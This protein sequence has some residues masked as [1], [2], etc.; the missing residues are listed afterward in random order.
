MVKQVIGL[1]KKARWKQ[2]IKRV[3]LPGTAIS[4]FLFSILLLSS[5]GVYGVN[6]PNYTPY[7]SLIIHGG[8]TIGALFPE[9]NVVDTFPDAIMYYGNNPKDG[10]GTTLIVVVPRNAPTC[11][12]VPQLTPDSDVIVDSI[13][14]VVL[15]TDTFDTSAKVADTAYLIH[16]IYNFANTTDSFS[17]RIYLS[18]T[19]D[20]D[21][22][23]VYYDADTDGVLDTTDPLITTTSTM[24]QGDTMQIIIPILISPHTTLPD[25]CLVRIEVWS[26]YHSTYMKPDSDVADTSY[27]IVTATVGD[28]DSF[29][30]SSPTYNVTAGINFILYITP[31]DPAWNPIYGY[32]GDSMYSTS[33][34]TIT[35]DRVLNT[36]TQGD[37]YT[38]ENVSITKT[39]YITITVQ[40]GLGHYG[41]IGLNVEPDT[42]G[43]F[44]I[45]SSSGIV[46]AGWGFN[47]SITA[48]DRWG[49]QANDTSFRDT[50]FFSVTTGCSITP[51]VTGEFRAGTVAL[52]NVTLNRTGTIT[53]TVYYANAIGTTTL[54]VEPDTTQY[55]ALSTDTSIVAIGE[56]FNL[57]I[58]AYDRFGNINWNHSDSV[59]LI[60]SK[61]DISPDTTAGFTSGIKTLAVSLSQSGTITITA[62]TNEG[63]YGTTS[64]VV[65]PIGVE[66]FII[67]A[68]V[69]SIT[70]G[71]GFSL[72]ITAY[73]Q[74]NNVNLDFEDSA[75][76]S[77]STGVI[78]PSITDTF[79]SGTCAMSGVTIDKAGTQVIRV[80]YGVAEGTTV[81][82]IIPDTPTYFIVSSVSE[83][84]AG[85][86]FNLYITAYD[87][88][89]NISTVY[90]DSVKLIVDTGN[91][92]PDSAYGFTDGIKVQAVSVT[93]TGTRVITVTDAN[94]YATGT[95]TIYVTPDSTAYFEISGPDTV[96]TG[97]T[98]ILQITAYDRFWNIQTEFDSKILFYISDGNIYPD[99]SGNFSSGFREESVSI[100]KT[101]DSIVI[102]CSDPITGSYDTF[103][104]QVLP[105]ELSYFMISSD[106]VV[107]TAGYSFR[108]DV[109]AFDRFGNVK[110]DYT[111]D[112][113]LE[114]SSGT[115]TPVMTGNFTGGTVTVYPVTLTRS[116]TITIT[117]ETGTIFGTMQIWVEPDTTQYFTLSTDT[118][119]V[120]AGNSFVL[121]ITAYDRFDNINWNYLDT[122]S[123]LAS[124]GIIYPDTARFSTYG[125]TV[126]L[127]AV[128]LTKVGNITITAINNSGRFGTTTIQVIPAAVDHFILS[129]SVTNITAGYPFILNITAYD[130]FNNLQTLFNNSA[131]LTVTAGTITPSITAAF[132]SGTITITGVT[133]DRAGTQTI[134]CYYGSATGTTVIYIIPDTPTYFVLK[135]SSSAVAG[136]TFSLEI[137]ACDRFRNVSTLYNETASISTD[138]GIGAWIYPTWT[139]NFVNGTTVVYVSIN[140]TGTRTIT[141]RDIWD[142]GTGTT[143]ILITPDSTSYFVIAMSDT[144]RAGVPFQMQITA[145]DIFDNIQ[146]NFDDTVKIEISS[147]TIY[148][149]VTGNF[150]QGVI[151]VNNVT[152]T[153]IGAVVIT[154]ID[155][156]SA[157]TATGTK[158]VYVLPGILSYFVVTT[159]TPEIPAGETFSITITAYD[160]IGNIK[161]DSNIY[162]SLLVN[163]GVI[164]PTIADTMLDSGTVTIQNVTLTKTGT[165]TITAYYYSGVDTVYGADTILVTPGS[166]SYFIISVDTNNLQLGDSFILYVTAYDRFANIRL[167]KFD[168]AIIT[169]DDPAEDQE[170]PAFLIMGDSGCTTTV[171]YIVAQPNTT[172]IVIVQNG[173]AQGTVPIILSFEGIY[174]LELSIPDTTIEAGTPFTLRVTAVDPFGYPIATITGDTSASYFYFR[175]LGGGPEDVEPDTFAFP[176]EFNDGYYETNILIITQ[177]GVDTLEVSIQSYA[178]FGVKTEYPCKIDVDV[179]PAEHT[180][181]G[182]SIVGGD[183]E[184]TAGETFAL[185]VS[186]WDT[187]ANLVPING[188]TVSIYAYI[189]FETVPI[190]TNASGV[191]NNGT[192]VT[193]EI[194]YRTGTTQIIVYDTLARTGTLT[195][196]IILPAELHHFVIDTPVFPTAGVW[197]TLKVTARDI[198]ENLVTS[199]TGKVDFEVTEI[200]SGLQYP[201]QPQQSNQFTNG[202]LVQSVSITYGGTVVLTVKDS[203]TPSDSGSIIFFISLY[204]GVELTGGDTLYLYPGERGYITLIVKNYGEGVDIFDLSIAQDYDF[205]VKFIQ[206]DDQD[207]KHDESETTELPAYTD[208]IYP[209]DT[210]SFFV[211]VDVPSTTQVLLYNYII[212]AATSRANN[213]KT[214]TERSLVITVSESIPATT[215]GLKI[216]TEDYPGENKMYIEIILADA[217]TGQRVAPHLVE[218]EFVPYDARASV[219]YIP[220]SYAYLGRA[221]IWYRPLPEKTV[222]VGL[223]GRIGSFGF[224]KAFVKRKHT[225]FIVPDPDNSQVLVERDILPTDTHF[226]TIARPDTDELAIINAAYDVLSGNF[227]LMPIVVKSP[228]INTYVPHHKFSLLDDQGNINEKPQFIKPV[229]II[230]PYPDNDH[231]GVVDEFGIPE[232]TLRMYRLNPQAQ[233]WELV[234]NQQRNA[235]YDYVE[236]V[237]S[238]FSFYTLLGSASTNALSMSR[239]YP[240]PFYPL[241]RQ[242]ITINTFT[243]ISSLRVKIYNIAGDLVRTLDD[244]S[245]IISLDPGMAVWDGKNDRGNFVASG[246]YIF[247]AE[248]NLGTATGK[249]TLIK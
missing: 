217:T 80:A 127:S 59:T 92:V 150:N 72:Y 75:S 55:F 223:D 205:A 85:D 142:Y 76:L 126:V 135:V 54:W 16:T 62:Y 104:I 48:F 233:R 169:T 232:S 86:T 210:Y 38:I 198:Y 170:T 130:E 6:D 231:N 219:E 24:N 176:I 213:S 137:T 67:T 218:V 13:Y 12:P 229:R 173:E 160:S 124:D 44:L 244:G 94:N 105:S 152:V 10:C 21:S 164:T 28:I 156:S 183:T 197:F 192:C 82:Y 141:V 163:L 220:D 5:S 189:D 68:N 133:I 239:S 103:V 199:Y 89:W 77:V 228:D 1:C 69:N 98:F 140:R 240:N 60:V 236:A 245:E 66:Y 116:G 30:I 95:T 17:F 114:V 153:K 222:N 39:G 151:V 206:D 184:I 88:F 144:V 166:L 87:R 8:D 158:P 56:N 97:D 145:Y 174:T 113:Y 157:T 49:N 181:Y 83:I 172:T 64:I 225:T 178:P 190:L 29:V 111:G 162:I 237:V 215:L 118:S 112:A 202:V 143:S 2:K 180:R 57:S 37:G 53:I 167:N 188:G 109:T 201:I 14:F 121:G 42:I 15:E 65:A 35:P 32:S 106:S 18:D 91:I 238:E 61:G 22:A 20:Y 96:L 84:V 128:S 45:S 101:G 203:V 74:Y 107:V 7:Q 125:G 138:T 234:E 9:L 179:D 90:S 19:I 154:C 52:S 81:I 33:R 78:V 134:T 47:L 249:I 224:S 34:D 149:S 230:I 4:V 212:V 73:D 235:D 99:I 191:L 102:T 63:K 241:Q 246:L 71:Y 186:A 247:V 200:Q 79:T 194:L 25:T 31:V 207:N 41:I 216:I 122:V 185:Q 175:I 40:D 146:T 195:P 221:K 243:T 3:L 117:V 70:A 193:I 43:S 50:A 204:S 211:Y 129:A 226:I 115:I 46:T 27:D 123:I 208:L 165:V 196:L 182:V 161:T 93:K 36:F 51:E 168:T 248:T 227:A 147:G 120:V 214:D 110:T 159:D 177:A 11:S 139:S 132:T 136:D 131:Y 26:I 100:T 148:P 58:T 119:I 209:L 242:T 171:C 108:L 187:W 155:G 23:G